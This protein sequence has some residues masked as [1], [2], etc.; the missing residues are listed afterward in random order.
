MYQQLNSIDMLLFA[1]KISTERR[2]DLVLFP[3]AF[4]QGPPNLCPHIKISYFLLYDLL[5]INL[6]KTC[7]RS[8]RCNC[9]C[10]IRNLYN[11]QPVT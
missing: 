10:F 2:P 4:T 1:G 6:L 5:E 7:Q 8:C 11:R 3:L 9:L